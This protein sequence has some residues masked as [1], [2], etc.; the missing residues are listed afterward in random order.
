LSGLLVSSASLV[1]GSSSCV[2][3]DEE[4][5][6]AAPSG[7]TLL[8]RHVRVSHEGSMT[9]QRLE[10]VELGAIHHRKHDGDGTY[11]N[12]L[13]HITQKKVQHH[14]QAETQATGIPTGCQ[15]FANACLG[16][17][18]AVLNSWGD[19]RLQLFACC[20]M[21]GHALNTCKGLEAEI[22]AESVP[23]EEIF[24]AENDLS[25]DFCQEL[26]SILPAQQAFVNAHHDSFLLDTSEILM[27]RTAK[28]ESILTNSSLSTKNYQWTESVGDESIVAALQL[29]GDSAPMTAVAMLATKLVALAFPCAA[30][31]VQARPIALV[32]FGQTPDAPDDL[33]LT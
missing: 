12:Q 9:E 3:G 8:Q 6:C 17:E 23:D 16:F 15:K 5:G 1:I 18:W 20:E 4:E 2:T 21:G 19:V 11:Y 27:Q 28:W 32:A 24:H 29:P 30:T 7:N 25:Y 22:M 13:T 31:L 14:Q 10:D 26:A 33:L